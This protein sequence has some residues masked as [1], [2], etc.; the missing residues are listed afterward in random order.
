[1][2]S[3]I[4]GLTSWWN[5]NW[6][7]YGTMSNDLAA[8]RNRLVGVGFASR[9]DLQ[10]L[11]DQSRRFRT[12]AGKCFVRNSAVLMAD[13]S[14]KMIYEIV[15]GDMVFSPQG[16]AKIKHL[17]RTVLGERKMYEMEDGSL[18]WSSEHMFWTKQTEREWFWTMSREDLNFQVA[19]MNTP[20]LNDSS[21]VYQ[22]EVEK[23]ELFAHIGETWKK[24]K[25][26]PS[27]IDAYNFPL[28][29]PNTENGEM[30]VVNGYL[31]DSWSD[32]TKQEYTKL[33]WEDW[34]TDDVR[35]ALNNL[36]HSVKSYHDYRI[37]PRY[38]PPVIPEGA[39][40]LIYPNIERIAREEQENELREKALPEDKIME[41]LKLMDR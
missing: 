22:G 19:F 7:G 26:M 5:S 30:I 2:S 35:A 24:I 20:I 18:E 12:G 23:E 21:S 32:E 3:D 17:H 34:V 29:S 8:I 39:I 14:W 4:G 36:P 13:L 28:L 31:V 38:E 41:L 9:Y 37:S 15:P 6:S 25:P 11:W 10:G 27:S 33:K 16:P 40:K 1:M